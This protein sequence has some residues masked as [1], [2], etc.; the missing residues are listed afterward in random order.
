MIRQMNSPKL[1]NLGQAQV[2]PRREEHAING[3]EVVENKGVQVVAPSV[4]PPRRN[5]TG[6]DLSDPM[7][8]WRYP[9][10]PRNIAVICVGAASQPRREDLASGYKML[11]QTVYRGSRKPVAE[12]GA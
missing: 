12:P 1:P 2:R 7:G 4:T 10:L 11:L 6:A 5:D 8:H 9:S 3:F